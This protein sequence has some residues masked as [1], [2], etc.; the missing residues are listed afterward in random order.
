MRCDLPK[1][2]VGLSMP[3]A[4]RS[5]KSTRRRQGRLRG[6]GLSAAAGLL[7]GLASALPTSPAKSDLHDAGYCSLALVLALDASSSVDPRE[8]QL[9]K[10]GLATALR[11]PEVRSVILTLGGVMLSAFE[12]SGR[13]QQVIVAD[14]TLLANDADIE[15]FAAKLDRFERPYDEFPTALGYALGFAAVHLRRAPR[16]CGRRVIDIAGDGVHN[17][18]FAPSDAYRNFDFAGVTVNGLVIKG[19]RPDPEP[20]Y[21]QEVLFGPGAFLQITTGYN[22]YA[23]A[24]KRKLLREISGS[25]VAEAR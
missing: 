2:P 20:Y 25:I 10:Q 7:G 8:Y 19:S 9:Q 21:R 17:E 14:W 12:W 11:D 15:G 1:G 23:R 22:D 16:N 3:A 13:N 24:M 5:A 6:F 18:G 4:E